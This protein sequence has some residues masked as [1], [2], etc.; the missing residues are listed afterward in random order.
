MA[1]GNNALKAKNK[2]QTDATKTVD[3]AVTEAE[4]TVEAGVLESRS[5]DV[6]VIANLGDP[7]DDDT[8][9]IETGGT[10]S[11]IKKPRIVGYRIKNVSDQ[12]IEWEEFG[13]TEKWSKN[14]RLDRGATSESKV[15]APGETAD[16]TLFET[17]FL[18]SRPEFNAS[19]SGGD[20]PVTGSYPRPKNTSRNDSAEL[21]EEQVLSFR[22][23]P[24]PRPGQDN[25]RM[26]DLP[27]EEI[28]TFEAEQKENGRR[29]ITSR[30]IKPEFEK[31]APVANRSR[32]STPRRGGKSAAKP[33]TYN[34]L[35]AAFIRSAKAN[36]R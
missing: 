18:I 4:T 27:Y 23:T 17:G 16:L 20:F 25:F 3:K 10:K 32:R 26:A 24:S 29:S 33:K 28:L 36:T 11:T 6:A 15:L 2:K 22:L 7:S 34:P 12:P 14:N 1:L 5:K 30:T 13:L 35:A 9:T 19:F 31:F 8:I 21:T